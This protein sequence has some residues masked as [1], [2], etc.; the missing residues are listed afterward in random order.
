MTAARIA[1]LQPPYEPSVEETL[2]KWM[3][4]GTGLEPPWAARFP[5]R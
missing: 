2:V 1:P 3:Q 5:A 4:P